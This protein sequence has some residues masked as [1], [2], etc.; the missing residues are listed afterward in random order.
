[1]AASMAER[2]EFSV[3]GPV[4]VAG[5]QGTVD[6]GAP[7]HRALLAL[8]LLEP[9]RVVSVDRLIDRLWQGEPPAAAT[10]TLQAYVSNLRRVLEPERVAGA[11]ATVLVTRPP[12]YVLDIAPEQV[13]AVRFER[14]VSSALEAVERGRLDDAAIYLADALALWRGAPL[15]DVAYEQWAQSEC[16]RLMELHLVALETQ[17]TIDLE[18]GRHSSVTVEAERLAKEY[19]V[20]ERFRELLM[21]ALYRAGRQADA[22]RAFQDARDLLVEEL[23]IEPG[24]GLRGLEERILA[25]DP[26]LGWQ[27]PPSATAP[28]QASPDEPGGTTFVGRE[29]ER[30]RLVG[31]LAE[32]NAANG[33]LVLVSGEPGI[34]KT[35]LCEELTVQARALGMHVVWARGWEGDGAPAFWPWVQVLRAFADSLPEATITAALDVGGADIARVVPDYGR[36]VTVPDDAPDAET[37]RF[38]FFEAVATMLHRLAQDAPL[39][40]VLDDLHWADQSSLRLL[41]Y[42]VHALEGSRVLLVGT[43]RDAES[44]TPPLATTLATLARTPDLERLALPGL[45]VAEIGDYVAAVIGDEAA[46]DLA[47]SLH[48]RTAGNPFF[49][50]ELVRLFQYEGK[51]ETPEGTAV[52]EG[53]RDVIRT[54]LARLPDDAIPVLTAGAIA[55]REFDIALVAQVCGIDEDRALDLVEAAWMTGVVDE[56]HDGMGHF[57]FSHEL[58]RE[59]LAEGLSALRRIRLHRRIGEAIETLHGERN[60]GFL[61]ECAHHFSEAAP[62]GDAL[63]AVLY[64]QKAADRLSAQLAY[65]DAIPT[66]ERA[67]DLIDTYNVGSWQTGTDLLIGL[68]WALR[69][70]GRLGDARSAMRRAMDRAYSEGDP[71]R[72]ARAVLGIGGGSFWGWWDEF[73]VTDTDLVAY[74]ER[75]LDS[76]DKEDSVLR[77]ELIARLAVEGYFAMPRYRRRSLAAEALEM[78]RRLDD[79]VALVAALASSL[80]V[81]WSHDNLETRLAMDDELVAVAAMN[82]IPYAE[83]IGRHFRMVDHLE[84]GDRAA[85]DA[86]FA[87]CVQLSERLGHHAFHVQLAWYRAMLAFV[88]GR[89]TDAEELVDAAFETNV[90]SNEQAAWM[91]YGAQMYRLRR[92]QGRHAELEEILRFT[93]DHQPQVAVALR[94]GLATTAAEHGRIDEAR[95]MIDALLTNDEYDDGNDLLAPLHAVQL[96]EAAVAIGHDAAAVLA[97][98]ILAEH[99]GPVALLA[100]GHLCFGAVD[101]ARGDA[102]RALGRLD[103]AIACYENAI[104]VEESIGA[105]LYANRSRLGLAE[106]LSARGEPED[107]ERAEAVATVVVRVGEELGTPM[108]ADAARALL[109]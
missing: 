72:I 79:P 45:T 59:T 10:S 89:I 7:K 38:R 6:I 57:R 28:V 32:I 85:A 106:A 71:V 95:E 93:A 56:A 29:H 105:R 91:A 1:M 5:D 44:R 68:G 14:N 20:R 22:L 74:L 31:R 52:P 18:R 96:A 11:A 104:D 80:L 98:K 64:G 3:L 19:P 25:Q 109:G 60:P 102:L 70:T 99:T 17:L 97:E 50:G 54:R 36:F 100:T 62:A 84:A 40:I 42:A 86:D 41:E 24:P 75:A 34:G 15:A 65:E 90:A 23:G 39:V 81:C 35:R 53:V 92:E 43:Y 58:V 94:T 13:D 49:V 73:G 55:G 8:L 88:D 9:G 16:E 66:Y 83:L 48:D 12:G 37:A 69:A 67:L 26:N 61:T 77:C 27:P 51:L 21:L 76:L 63:K 46:G 47:D 4:Q 78:A 33:R 87:A 108:V 107:L 101:R 2:L 30:A 103:E 82:A